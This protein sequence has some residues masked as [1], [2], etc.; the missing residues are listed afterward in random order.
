MGNRVLEIVVY[1]IDHMRENSGMLPS[2]DDLTPDLHSLGYSDTEISTAYSWVIDR[3][4]HSNEPFFAQFPEEHHSN[5]VLTQ[6]ERLQ[7][8]PEAYGFMVKLVALSVIDDEQFETVLERA[9][10]ISP[11][12]VSLEQIK[13]VTA[14]V[15]FNEFSEIESLAL[16]DPKIDP[17]LTVN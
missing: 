9:F 17:T 7:L 14:A 10:S 15:L 12:R 2:M 1:L 4:E 5:R 16:F 8:T 6:Y 11:Q 3:Y 13:L